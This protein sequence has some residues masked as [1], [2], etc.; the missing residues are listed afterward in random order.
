VLDRLHR[1]LCAWLAPMLPFT[2]EEAWLARFGEAAESVH[3]QLF[4]EIP[5]EWRDPA[6]AAKWARIRELRREV[7][8]ELERARAAGEM[9]SSLQAAP[10]LA[11]PESDLGLLDAAGWAEVCIT[12][13]FALEPGPTAAARFLPA[14]GRK[15][16]RCWKLLP[17]VGASAAH[18][19]L[20]RRCE[21]VVEG[22]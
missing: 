21:A 11:L 1:C 22:G 9:G 2:A 19:G 15:C 18:P 17:E 13:G 14:P 16:E 10:V 12:S 3:L 7:T 6:L 4:P 5:A 20:C 8:A